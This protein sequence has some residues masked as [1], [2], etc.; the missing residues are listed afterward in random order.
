M[1]TSYS[2][3]SFAKSSSANDSTQTSEIVKTPTASISSSNSYGDTVTISQEALEAY[4]KLSAK[5]VEEPRI[6][7]LTPKEEKKYWYESINR[8]NSE[9]N[10]K[11]NSFLSVFQQVQKTGKPVKIIQGMDTLSVSKIY[12]NKWQNTMTKVD[13]RITEILNENNITLNENETLNFSINKKGKITID[14][15]INEY[16]KTILE[17]IFNE[18]NELRANLLDSHYSLENS[19]HWLA[20]DSNPI[21]IADFD[22]NF[23]TSD[24]Y[25]IRN[26]GLS[27]DDFVLTSEEEKLAGALSIKFK[28]ETKDNELLMNMF[29]ED[30]EIYD[31]IEN[32]LE[33]EKR[34]GKTA[35]ENNYSFSYKNGVTIEKGKGDQNSLDKRYNYLWP[36]GYFAI[37]SMTSAALTIDPSGRVVD[38]QIIDQTLVNDKDKITETELDLYV[39]KIENKYNNNKF[40]QYQSWFQQYVFEAQRLAKYKTGENTENMNLT[41]NRIFGN[42]RIKTTKSQSEI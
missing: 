13:E 38:S 27:S 9:N 15:G 30:A 37:G 2:A 26:Y 6:L 16:K 29:T 22:P 33:G 32:I 40:F 17:K 7:D 39:P 11:F 12:S 10:K 36:N 4:E 34:K 42:E 21:Y 28:D 19:S 31:Y 3:T 8:N 24:V 35:S 23:D 41:I 18:D 5:D 1:S 25:L 20:S 14:K